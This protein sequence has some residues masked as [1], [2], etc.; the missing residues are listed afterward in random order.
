MVSEFWEQGQICVTA[1]IDASRRVKTSATISRKM[2]I[3][4]RI[5]NMVTMAFQRIN[6]VVINAYKCTNP[7]FWTIIFTVMYITSQI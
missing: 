5:G 3:S 7:S 6:Y 1:K 2:T 4:S